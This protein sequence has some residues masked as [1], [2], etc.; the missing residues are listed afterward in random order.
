MAGP[1]NGFNWNGGGGAVSNNGYPQ[2]NPMPANYIQDPPPRSFIPG[3]VVNNPNE[4]MPK[5]VPMDGNIA[6][7]PTGDL[8]RIYL[9]AWGSDGL[10]RT[11]PFIQEPEMTQQE[12]P[13][14]E[15][16]FRSEVFDRLSNIEDILNRKFT[17]KKPNYNNNRKNQ[18]RS[19]FAKPKEDLK[20]E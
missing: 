1:N 14:P 19:N 16:Q 2:T 3:R 11:I 4:I 13:S 18:N 6:L 12:G 17:Y 8:S 10:I 15:E 20:S 9:K 7:F 5:E